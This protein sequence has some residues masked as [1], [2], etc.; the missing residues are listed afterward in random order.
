LLQDLILIRNVTSIVIGNWRAS[1]YPENRE[2]LLR[3]EAQVLKTIDKLAG[4]SPDEV[5]D[6]FGR[7]CRL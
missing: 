4:L 6:T 3:S 7:A 2:Y 1:Q 5:A